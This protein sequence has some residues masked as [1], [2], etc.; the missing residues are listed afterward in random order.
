MA[1]RSPFLSRQDTRLA[2]T[3]AV[4]SFLA[5]GSGCIA[6]GSAGIGSGTWARNATAWL[7]GAG[8]AGVISRIRP[9]SLSRAVLLLT[10]LALLLSLVH[11]GQ[12]GVHRWISSGPLTWNAALLCLPAATVALASAAQSGSR[13]TW[14]VALVIE[15]ELCFQPDAS[16][17]T[18]FAAAMIVILL[19]TRTPGRVRVT[20]CLLLL[21][22]AGTSWTRPDPLRPVPEV[23]GIIELARAVSLG[24]AAVCAASLAAACLSPLALLKRAHLDARSP[25]LAVSAYFLGCALLPVFGAFPVPLVGMGMSPIIG[26]WGGFGALMA[27]SDSV[28]DSA[29]YAPEA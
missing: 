7:V 5:V 12:S 15:W 22:G 26:F 9:A 14:W 23:E 27:V 3:F 21:L 2:V 28:A 25:A 29:V 16:Q 10:P 4:A 24:L 6:A 11:S 13:W 17:A 8:L 19:T 1:N 20:A 18:A